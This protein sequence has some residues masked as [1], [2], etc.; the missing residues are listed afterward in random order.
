MKKIFINRFHEI[1]SGWKISLVLAIAF[2]TTIIL[3]VVTGVVFAVT[4]HRALMNS[5]I[6]RFISRMIFPLV[7]IGSVFLVLKFIDKKKAKDIGITDLRKDFKDLI[8]GLVLG[9]VSMTG[10]FFVL[11]LTGNVT[12]ENNFSEPILSSSIITGFILFVAV[13]ISEELF[14]RGYGMVVLMQTGNLWVAVTVSSIL[15]SVLHTLNPNVSMVG[16]LN[17]FLVGIFFAYMFLKTG[18]LWMPIGYHIT[19]NYVQGNI[20]GFPVS[21]T[22]PEGIYNIIIVHDNILTGGLFGP[23]GGILATAAILIGFVAVGKYTKNK[24]SK[25]FVSLQRKYSGRTK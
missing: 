18:S 3:S 4:T 25:R 24:Y 2:V 23:E 6:V 17:I 16:L 19:W 20:F 21:G 14:S 5:S 10:I 9:V 15:F 8:F 7:M 1:R 12:L 11:L 13:G 22:E